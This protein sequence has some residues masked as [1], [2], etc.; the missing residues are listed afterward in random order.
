MLTSVLATAVYGADITADDACSLADA[1]TAANRDEAVDGCVAG[2]GA[3]VITLSEDVTLEAEL[4]R[5]TSEITVEGGGY[6][7][8]GAEAYRIFYVEAS[9]TLT[10]ERLTLREGRAGI[11]I[12]PGHWDDDGGAVYNE[13]EL[14]IKKSIFVDNAAAWGG[15]I[16]NRSRLRVM[17]ST[18]VNCSGFAGGGAIFSF[19]GSKLNVNASQF[20]SN[21]GALGGAI[22]ILKGETFFLGGSSFTD[23]AASWGGAISSQGTLVIDDSTFARNLAESGGAIV[24]S[25]ELSVFD[26][27]FS[28]NYAIRAGAIAN[29]G[30]LKVNRSKFTS[31]I[32]GAGGSQVAYGKSTESNRGY[33]PY[34]TGW[35]GAIR[36][37]ED[38]EVTIGES[39]FTDNAAG[40]GGAVF[41][42]GALSVTS[43]SFS[44]NGADKSGGGL[45]LPNHG[46]GA[47]DATLSH[48]TLAANS[49][50]EGGGIHTYSSP[51][52]NV[53]LYNSILADNAGGDCVGR[54]TH[55]ASN[56]IADGS[57]DAEISGDPMLGELVRPEDGSPAYY[58]LQPGSPAID[59]A[60]SDHCPE[61]DQ[62][63][64]PRPQ[65]EACDIGAIEFVPE[66]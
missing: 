12:S 6:A 21:S 36:N 44:G 1:I 30:D 33:H 22:G 16:A 17:E 46:Q 57:C 29:S 5:I 47:I 65:G 50:D 52:A 13:G 35:G 43:T 15:A 24:S 19:D 48:L 26:T 7:I 9:G 61:T 25:G 55:S 34:V 60:S 39:S 3:D 41:S 18:F 54:L 64:T 45:F 62:I 10:V 32:A 38:G 14:S 40:F 59:A 20:T 2:A 63:G 28:G 4:P 56:L 11:E 58:P 23:N 66:Q 37:D 49:A 27:K 51:E 53:R 42:I 8:S 31:N